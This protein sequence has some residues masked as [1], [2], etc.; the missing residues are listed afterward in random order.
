M[1]DIVIC[2]NAMKSEG[3][4]KPLAKTN[5]P[6]DFGRQVEREHPMLERRRVPRKD[7]LKSAWII[8]LCSVLE[9][10]LFSLVDRAPETGMV[11]HTTSETR[12]VP[13][14]VRTHREGPAWFRHLRGPSPSRHLRPPCSWHLHPPSGHQRPSPSTLRE[15][16]TL[17]P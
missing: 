4:G 12:M 11:P 7:L 5:R 3:K 13:P 6:G 1:S 15:A 8:K 14:G 2:P 16:K 10:S 9:Y 17:R